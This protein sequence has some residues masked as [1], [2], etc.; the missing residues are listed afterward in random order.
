MFLQIHKGLR[1]LLYETA[2]KLQQSDFWHLEDAEDCLERITEVIVLFEKHAHSEDSIVFPAIAKYEPSIS[3]V[4]LKGHEEDH[5]LSARLNAAISLYRSAPTIDQKV[6]AAAQVQT[7]FTK[8]MIFNIEH[9]MKEE[10]VL[11][12]L[13]WRYYSDKDLLE[14]TQRIV[15]NIAH[16]KLERYN[17]WMMRG[18]NN[19]E[20]TKWL[21]DVERH[22]PERVF[23]ELFQTA[24]R[25]LSQKRFR[26]VLES[27]TEG[28][29]LA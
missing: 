27:L 25:E 17:K 3:D 26:E 6:A 2:L 24:E 21:K 18:L 23:Q 14:M 8:F 20:I 7:A 13:L 4:F 9:M 29:M 11:N 16:D 5:K 28:A 22:A 10:E 1:A 12:P 19:A 15:T